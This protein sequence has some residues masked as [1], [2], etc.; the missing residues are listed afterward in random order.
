MPN[1]TTGIAA[2]LCVAGFKIGEDLGAPQIVHFA[3]P[4]RKMFHLI[5]ICATICFVHS[6][7]TPTI[8]LLT[9]TG[10]RPVEGHAGPSLSGSRPQLSIAQPTIHLLFGSSEISE[11]NAYVPR[12]A[13]IAI[14]GILMIGLARRPFNRP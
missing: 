11:I 13:T 4:R 1:S 6:A 12:K 5:S 9:V 3:Q 8:N 10:K 14:V 7:G 2:R